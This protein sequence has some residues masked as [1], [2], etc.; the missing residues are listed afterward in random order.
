MRFFG[1]LIMLIATAANREAFSNGASCPSDDAPQTAY[2]CCHSD[3]GEAIQ[4]CPEP[5]NCTNQA[6]DITPPNCTAPYVLSADGNACVRL[7][8][9]DDASCMCLPT[10]GKCYA[11]GDVPPI[12]AN[13]ACCQGADIEE[14]E[15]P[16]HEWW[17]QYIDDEPGEGKC[18]L[19]LEKCDGN[20]ISGEYCCFVNIANGTAYSDSYKPWGHGQN[21]TGGVKLHGAKSMVLFGPDQ[22]YDED[23]EKCYD[24]VKKRHFSVVDDTCFKSD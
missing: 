22:A 9:A 13:G 15:L 19:V 23:K 24:S 2:D 14:P 21:V 16:H 20:S 5:Y 11:C 18:T 7:C 3:V 17:H 4:A 8:V 10:P 12:G 1:L 6:N